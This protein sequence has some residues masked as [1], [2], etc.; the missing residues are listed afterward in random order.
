MNYN[1]REIIVALGDHFPKCFFDDPKLRRPLK[2]DIV[3]DIE[4]RGIP[5]LSELSIQDAVDWYTSHYGYY[6]GT[7]MAGT[8]RIDLDGQRCGSVTPA[9]AREAVAEINRINANKEAR[10]EYNPHELTQSMAR[11]DRTP[12]VKPVPPSAPPLTDGELL[13]RAMKKIA[14]VRPI[15]EG[16]NDDGLRAETA[17]PILKSIHEDIKNLYDRLR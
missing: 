16:D 2:K 5:E 6:K 11:G 9:E 1:P 17:A 8:P 3:A 14:R 13:Q 15:I 4:A 12:I 7:A 10:G